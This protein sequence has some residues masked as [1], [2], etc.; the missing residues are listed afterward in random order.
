[1]MLTAEWAVRVITMT[2]GNFTC[3]IAAACLTYLPQEQRANRLVA[4][5]FTSFQVRHT[6]VIHVCVRTLAH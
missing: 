4:Y 3:I 1:M 6:F 5:C 2:L